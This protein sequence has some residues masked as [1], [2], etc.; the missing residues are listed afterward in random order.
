MNLYINT[1][2]PD[3]PGEYNG[4][5]LDDPSKKSGII[6][7]ESLKP[8]QQSKNEH[9]DKKDA[10]TKAFDSLARAASCKNVCYKTKN[11]K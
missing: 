9:T 11:M 2:K 4:M 1:A 3:L 8:N 10:I 5:Y 7:S 6:L